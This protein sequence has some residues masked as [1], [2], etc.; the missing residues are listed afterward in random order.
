MTGRLY[1]VAT[2]IGN[3]KDI[4]LRALDVL[5]S[6]DVILCEDTR[7]TRKL[8]SHYDI[9]GRLLSFYEGNEGRRLPEVLEML[10]EGKT[11]SL[12]SDAGTPL[13]SD[14]GYRLVRACRER[15]IPVLPVPGPSAVVAALSVS[16]IGTDR[17]AFFGFPPKR[18]G[19]RRRWLEEAASF[20][21][22][23]VFYVPPHRVRRFL[24]EVLEV[25]GDR[26][27]CLC[28]E[29]TKIHEEYLFGRLSEIA[30]AVKERGE[31]VLVIGKPSQP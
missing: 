3:L 9:E 23:V 21:G 17:F 16:G 8:L 28:R 4:T 13:I 1:V 25:F 18:E 19:R 11:V 15:G 5:K 22:T 26:E 29:M 20:G 14:P 12:V 10:S 2:P 6:S 30:E 27:A 7:R 31:M 24:E